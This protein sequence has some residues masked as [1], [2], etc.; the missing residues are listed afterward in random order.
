[1]RR[2]LPELFLPPQCQSAKGQLHWILLLHLVL[3]FTSR[4]SHDTRA[5]QVYLQQLGKV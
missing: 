4:G 5:A 3:A 2:R 1:M